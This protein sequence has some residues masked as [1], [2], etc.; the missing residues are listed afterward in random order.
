METKARVCVTGAS[1]FIGSWLVKKLLEKGYVVHATVRNLGDEDKV[2]LLK[3]LPGADSRLSLFEANIYDSGTFGP[4]IRGC[5]FVFL[6]ATLYHNDP[7]NSKHKD[8]T[9]AALGAI[10]TIL[11][12]CEQSG[13]IRR[14]VYTG[15]ISAASPLKEDSASYRDSF[16]ESCWTSLGVSLPY[17]SDNFKAYI[18]SKTLSEK[19]ILIYNSKEGNRKFEVVSLTC[20]I[21][22]G[23][24]ILPY[25]SESMHMIISPLSGIEVFH[26]GLKALHALFASIPLV[27]VE[28]VCEAHVFCIERPVMAGRFFCATDYPTMKHVVDYFAKEFPELKLIKEVEGNGK[29]LKASSNKLVDLGFK[30]KYSVDEVLH[31]TVKCCKRLGT[32]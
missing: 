17:F 22:G 16:D 6:V 28:D 30:Y 21:V 20:G 26:N 2:G 9:E 5:H 4:A 23:D 13:T 31:E 15:S 14:V 1:G 29:I 25:A 11:R 10:S 32:L 3:S 7:L 19:E 18:R 12:L 24:T 8:T 27:H